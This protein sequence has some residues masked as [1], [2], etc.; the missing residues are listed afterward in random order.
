M[1][2]RLK[3]LVMY[4][5]SDTINLPLAAAKKLNDMVEGNHIYLTIRNT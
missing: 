5:L 1:V 3:L 2:S 4:K